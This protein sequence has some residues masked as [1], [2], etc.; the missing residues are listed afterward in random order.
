MIEENEKK[1]LQSVDIPVVDIT[2]GTNMYGRIADLPNTP[3]HVIAEFIDNAIQ[4]YRDNEQ[5]LRRLDPLYK[6]FV[7]I[8]FKWDEST[9]QAIEIIVHDNAG[10][11]STEKFADAFKLANTP[12][13]NKGLNEFGMGL[14]TAALWLGETW[15]VETSAIGELVS[16]SISFD[17]NLVMGNNLISLPV[18]TK[19]KSID[20][21]FTTVVI[22]N[23]TKN[24]PTIKSIDKIKNELSSIYRKFLRSNEIV[25]NIMG[26]PLVFEEPEI[27]VSPFAENPDGPIFTWKKEIH[28]S[29]GKYRADG[30]IALLK[31]MDS[32]KDGLVLLRRERVVVGAESDGRYHPKSLFGTVGSPRYKRMFGELELQGFDVAFNKNDLQDKENLEALMEALRGEIH[33]KQFDLYTQADKYRVDVRQKNVNKIVKEHNTRKRKQAESNIDIFTE[34][35]PQVTQQTKSNTPQE[36]IIPIELGHI[37]DKYRINGKDYEVEVKMFDKGKELIWLDTSK[38]KD[39]IVIC[40]INVGHIFFERMGKPNKSIVTI[41]KTMAL[42][43][44]IA[45]EEGNN[46]IA[47]MFDAFNQ[48]IKLSNI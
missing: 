23:P 45:R 25:I 24:S 30:F 19:E 3:S 1:N 4:S 16:R 39:N 17:L 6:L 43:R 47:E 15:S 5:E 33:T 28:F 10:G 42:A 40:C 9:K 37:N 34:T 20:E 18:Y 32:T 44:F 46:T 7:D 35:T 31:D 38:K 21:H 22:K 26:E 14:K 27:L 41:F 29:F 11:I 2:I 12:E 48:Y 8:T 13:N 36:E